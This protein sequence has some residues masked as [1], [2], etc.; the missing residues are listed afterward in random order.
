M[1]KGVFARAKSND[2]KEVAAPPGICSLADNNN[3]RRG[4]TRAR[5]FT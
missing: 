1:F 2:S 5:L 3:Y 4:A